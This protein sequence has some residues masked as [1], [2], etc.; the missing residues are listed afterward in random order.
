MSLAQVEGTCSGKFGY[1]VCV[2]VMHEIGQGVI[3]EGT[4]F[5]Q[6]RV[7]HTAIAFRPFKGEVMDTVVTSVSKARPTAF[8]Q[9]LAAAS[10]LHQHR[11]VHTVYILRRR[12]RRLWA[13]STAT[14]CYLVS[15]QVPATIL[16]TAVRALHLI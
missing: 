13:Y 10:R 12:F 14:P 5:A 4:G 1:I 2:P 8:V 3:R 16:P 11:A 9:W 7:R 6:F 15:A